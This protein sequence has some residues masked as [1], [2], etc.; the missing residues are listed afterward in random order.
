MHIGQSGDML[1]RDLCKIMPEAEVAFG[2]ASAY[3]ECYLTAVR[4]IEIQVMSDGETVLHFGE[5]DCTTQRRSHLTR[6]GIL[7][8]STLTIQISSQERRGKN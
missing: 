3:I 2:D 1:E 7:Q 6:T 5:R 8:F 4:D